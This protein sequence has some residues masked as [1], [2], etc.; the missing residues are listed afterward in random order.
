[1]AA[2]VQQTY[3]NTILNMHTFQKFFENNLWLNIVFLILSILSIYLA[4]YF[5]FKSKKEKLPVF[6]SKTISLFDAS[7]I[8]S[9]KLEIKY[10]GS[11]V[12]KLL[13]TRI[14]FWNAGRESIRFQDIA[15]NAPFLI[16][17]PNDV[18]IYDI[19]I[20]DQN[21][22]NNFKIEK[23][24]EQTIKV[25]FDFIDQN[26]GI[27]INIFRSSN[28]KDGLTISGKFIGSREISRGIKTDKLADKLEVLAKPLNYLMN[29]KG[30]D[31]KILAGLLVIPTAAIVIPLAF[32]ILPIDS[33]IN[34][35]SNKYP[36]KYFLTD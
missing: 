35:F 32:I 22:V 19:E 15:P 5:Y 14:A 34:K 25:T 3:F 30:F 11:I 31:K 20:V 27:I 7:P 10:N 18:I 26:D 6:N 33:I 9:S 23:L 28:M 8:I 13:L 1:L 29:E 16:T 17:A 12:N 2:I 4:F 24:N 36:K 21:P